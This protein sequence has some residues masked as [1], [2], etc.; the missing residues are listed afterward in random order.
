MGGR[1]CC[2]KVSDKTQWRVGTLYTA[3]TTDDHCETFGYRGAYSHTPEADTLRN[4]HTI[5]KKCMIK[6]V[7]KLDKLHKGQDM[8]DKRPFKQWS[9]KEQETWGMLYERQYGRARERASKEFYLDGF[10]HLNLIS[11]HLPDF[12]AL[13]KWFQHELGWELF[14]T[15]TQFADGQDWFEHLARKEFMLTEY[16]RD[17]VDLDYTP[18]PDIWHDVFG[19]LPLMTNR[20]Y[21]DL[22]HEFAHKMLK[23]TKE[24]RRGIGSIWWYTIEFGLIKEAGEI[25]VLGAGLASSFGEI[26]HAFSGQVALKPFDPDYIA[27][28]KPSPHEFHT[29]LF[30]LEDFSQF[31][32]F[33]DHWKA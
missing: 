20:R 9:A 29:E 32:D 8:L 6:C 7:Y 33:V 28:I 21:A 11:D 27:S 15:D 16:I 3:P 10:D 17:Q 5:C 26:E 19:H 22:V 18:L 12:E 31:E 23:Y 1:G 4:F 2:S 25:K 30:I 24:E 13:N 14:S